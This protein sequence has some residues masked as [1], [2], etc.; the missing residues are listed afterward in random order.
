MCPAEPGHSR[1]LWK[2]SSF[3][4]LLRKRDCR[5]FRKK[6]PSFRAHWAV[7][8]GEPSDQVSVLV[9]GEKEGGGELET[10]ESRRGEPHLL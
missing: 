10:L 3:Q 7:R 1:P 6:Y 2:R 8:A 5:L 4:G 9:Q